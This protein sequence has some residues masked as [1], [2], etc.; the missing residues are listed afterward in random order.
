M[1]VDTTLGKILSKEFFPTLKRVMEKWAEAKD[2]HAF[3]KIAQAVETEGKNF[4]AVDKAWAK[5]NGFDIGNGRKS[6]SGQEITDYLLQEHGKFNAESKL[7][8]A[9]ASEEDK[10]A[11]VEAKAKADAI[12][13]TYAEEMEKLLAEPFSLEIPRLIK[14]TDKDIRK[15]R[16]TAHDCF[17]LSPVLDLS[18]VSDINTA[19]AE[20][21]ED[22][23]V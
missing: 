9:G 1:K 20:P 7:S 4:D 15:A 21:E 8:L 10:D 13:H 14:V 18:G 22:E 23:E 2:I 12:L 16:I 5:A 11:F 19:S 3:V 6:V 17:I